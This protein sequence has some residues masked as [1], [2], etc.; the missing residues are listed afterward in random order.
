M[1]LLIPKAPFARLVKEILYFYK[2][3]ARISNQALACLQECAE[4]ALVS[5]FE[6]AQLCAIHAK[7]I[8]ILDRDIQLAKKI[9][10]DPAFKKMKLYIV[11]NCM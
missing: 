3:D 5:L 1:D 7:H 6:D 4:E 9:R 8:T 11:C 2:D 10:I